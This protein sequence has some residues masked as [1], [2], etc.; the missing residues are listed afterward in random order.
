MKAT[1]AVVGGEIVA[2][3]A[4]GRPSFQALQHR[5]AQPGHAI[6]F[7]AFDVLHV[8]GSNLTSHSL[9]SRRERLPTLLEN[10]GLW[11]PASCVEVPLK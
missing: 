11:S 9:D 5:R 3:D 2:V 6:A 1:S 8:D 7:Y 4:Q 10:T